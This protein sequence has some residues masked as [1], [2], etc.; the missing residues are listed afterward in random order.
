[1]PGR[2]EPEV[3]AHG[4]KLERV[5]VAAAIRV[6]RLQDLEH[7]R[8]AVDERR[9]GEDP[10]KELL[11]ANIAIAA[12]V[13]LGEPA[14]DLLPRVLRLD[15]RRLHRIK[16]LKRVLEVVARV[17]FGEARGSGACLRL[18]PV[19]ER[20]RIRRVLV[21]QLHRARHV[22]MRRCSAGFHD[23]ADETPIRRFLELRHL[24]RKAMGSFFGMTPAL[25]RI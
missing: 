21:G 9:L 23:A 8:N 4:L 16:L 10:R 3:V 13:H 19:G 15:T 5:E 18:Q 24:P 6:V 14:A 17:A 1:M 25:P 11:H 12:R 7:A 22:G 20:R 2:S